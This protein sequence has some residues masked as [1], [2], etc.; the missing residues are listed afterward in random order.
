[1]PNH[2]AEETSPYL[3]Q[4]ADNPVDWRAW[5]DETLALARA[6]GKPILLSGGPFLI[7]FFF[8][9]GFFFFFCFFFGP[10][11]RLFQSRFYV[12]RATPHHP[13]IAVLIGWQSGHDDR[14]LV[15]AIPFNL[16]VAFE[17]VLT[18][19]DGEVMDIFVAYIA[20]SQPGMEDQAVLA[21]LDRRISTS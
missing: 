2:L 17:M 3:L 14:E 8:F 11:S 20:L 7:L 15:L 18:V 5:N 9:F 16:I 4:H 1:M 10:R 6:T 21:Y 13:Q 19:F 12:P